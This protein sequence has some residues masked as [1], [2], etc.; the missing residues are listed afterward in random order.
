M[1]LARES[2]WESR[3]IQLPEQDHEGELV[4]DV[5]SAKLASEGL[6]TSIR[7][8]AGRALRQ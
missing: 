4:K 6:Q 3:S 1:E 5:I 8:R 2:V 7:W